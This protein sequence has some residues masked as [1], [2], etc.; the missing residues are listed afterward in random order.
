MYLSETSPGE[1]A[2]QSSHSPAAPHSL[3]S[4]SLIRQAAFDLLARR[5]HTQQEL[6]TKLIKRFNKREELAIDREMIVSVVEGLSTEGLQ[7]DGRYVEMLVYGRKK[8]GYGPVRIAQE[9]HQ[10]VSGSNPRDMIGEID[11][12]N[13][14]ERAREVR[15]KKFGEGLPATPKE[16]AQQM[17]FLQYRGFSSD[18]VRFALT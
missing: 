11:D 8:Q 18:Q 2:L 16:K 6:I 5:E 1:V 3:S 17:R 15:I 4:E 9:L 7:S 14:K 13:W 10:K 12:H